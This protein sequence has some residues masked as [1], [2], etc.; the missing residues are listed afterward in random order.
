MQNRKH[1]FAVNE[2]ILHQKEKCWQSVCSI[3]DYLICEEK[4]IFAVKKTFFCFKKE[5]FST[6]SDFSVS[7]DMYKQ[8]VKKTKIKSMAK[9]QKKYLK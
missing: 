5:F 4:F 8:T 2:I 9:D 7:V 3:K 6:E 1:F